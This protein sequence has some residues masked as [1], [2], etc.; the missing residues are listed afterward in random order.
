MDTLF[1]TSDYAFV[2]NLTLVT[3]VQ[4]CFGVLLSKCFDPD[5]DEFI[6]SVPVL[7][8]LLLQKCYDFGTEG[9]C[10]SKSLVNIILL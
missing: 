10:N 4:S 5:C 2:C 7:S 9:Y 3:L 8:R 1:L 6:A